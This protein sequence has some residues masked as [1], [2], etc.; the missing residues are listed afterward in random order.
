MK[1]KQ[2]LQIIFVLLI[3]IASVVVFPTQKVIANSIIV[4]ESAD[5]ATASLRD[6]WDMSEFSDI[7]QYLNQSGQVNVVK[8]ISVQNGIFSATSVGNVF[9][10]QNGWFHLLFP[11]YETAVHLGKIGSRYPIDA[12]KFSCFY[13]ATKINSGPNRDASGGGPDQHRIFWFANDRLNSDPTGYGFST[14]IQTYPQF[15]GIGTQPTPFWQLL[16]INL[17]TVTNIGPAS[18]SSHSEWQGLRFEPTIQENVSYEIDW[19]RLSDCTPNHV[20]ISF[21]PNLNIRSVWLQPEGTSRYILIA[22]DVVGS[23]GTYSLDV[24]GIAP[25]RYSVGFGSGSGTNLAP[26]C[27]IYVNPQPIEINQTPIVNFL[28]PNF[29]S[30]ED[31][32]ASQGN[33]WDFSSE[34]DFSGLKCAE[35]GLTPENTIWVNTPPP[36]LQSDE[37]KSWENIPDPSIRLAFSDTI[38]PA[39]YRYLTYHFSTEDEWQN[40]PQGMIARIIWSVQ[41]T[42]GRPGYECHLVSQDLPYDVGW[43]TYTIDLWDG[44]SGS[45]EEDAGECSSAYTHW[46]NSPPLHAFQFNPNENITSDYF[47]QEVDWIRLT[48]EISINQ[49]SKF[50]LRIEVN[51]PIDEVNLHFYYTTDP[52]NFPTQHLLELNSQPSSPTQPVEAEYKVFL[53]TI[54]R[55]FT[56]EPLVG[57]EF[58]WDTSNVAPGTYYICVQANDGYNHA[59]YCS[60]APVR[61]LP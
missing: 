43:Q 35:Y 37:C 55:N 52:K 13:I 6:A 36:H 23:S 40:V 1:R 38:N 3:L 17:E 57:E 34:D 4:A 11:G 30:G 21:T 24:Q 39:E 48:K 33:A 9:T 15:V 41:G 42:S 8:D 53:P 18:W 47:Y 26:T 46:L 50:D 2:T 49:G 32:A 28:S 22:E 51:K 16:K 31:F 29:D 60:E 5:Y 45:V 59:S 27:C 61:V 12:N 58:I 10:G 7:S 44:F 25:G 56:P 54:L 20:Q 14:G 19:A